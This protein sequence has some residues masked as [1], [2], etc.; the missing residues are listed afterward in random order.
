MP[1][2]ILS[3]VLAA[4]GGLWLIRN[5]HVVTL[6][7]PDEAAQGAVYRNLFFHVPAWFTCFTAFAFA[8]LAG[9]AYIVRKRMVFDT[10]AVA[11]VEVGL[12]FTLIGLATGS[13]WA[14]IIWGIWWTWDARLTWALITCL[15]YFGYL[16]LRESLDDPTSRARISAVFSTFAFVSVA[17]TYKSIEWWR[18]QHP[19]PV[20]DFRTGG[21]QIDKAMQSAL[22]H[23][24][25]ALMLI[26]AA[27]VL[28]RMRQ[29]DS[30]RELEALRRYVHAQ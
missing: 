21:G 27:L 28:I 4:A 14:R 16:M 10:L 30:R 13:I 6:Q 29:E 24:W 23:N 18:T 12:A 9:I 7:L 25:G 15:V 2:P 3:S 11:C 1:R 22:Y 17:I 20:L 8:G 5:L 26:A 19:G